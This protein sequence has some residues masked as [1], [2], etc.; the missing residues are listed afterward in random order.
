MSDQPRPQP[1]FQYRELTCTRQ[2]RFSLRLP[3]NARARPEERSYEARL[4]RSGHLGGGRILRPGRVR[5]ESALAV[6]LHF[7]RFIEAS[8]YFVKLPRDSFEPF[9]SSSSDIVASTCV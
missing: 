7:A 4:L 3:S 1:I 5:G 6:C 8:S 2:P 9:V